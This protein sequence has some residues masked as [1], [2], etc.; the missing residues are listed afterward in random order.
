MSKILAASLLTV[1]LAICVAVSHAVAPLQI[2]PGQL[3]FL[4]DA[5]LGGLSTVLAGAMLAMVIGVH[6]AWRRL[7]CR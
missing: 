6:P 1:A 5:G 4:S 7:S 3:R 2:G